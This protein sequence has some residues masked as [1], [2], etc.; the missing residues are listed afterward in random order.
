MNHPLTKWVYDQTDK[1]MK[2]NKPCRCYAMTITDSVMDKGTYDFKLGMY[3]FYVL[4]LKCEGLKKRNELMYFVCSV[5]EKQV[6]DSNKSE[7]FISQCLFHGMPV[8][9]L[10]I[11]LSK[12]DSDDIDDAR[13]ACCLSS[14]SR[15]KSI[16]SD[17]EI[18]MEAAY[19]RMMVKTK[20]F[21]ENKISEKKERIIEAE[22][23]LLSAK[24]E[25][26]RI[27]Y[28]RILPAI[29]GQL[30]TRER[31]YKETIDDIE[32]K[33]DLIPSIEELAIGV[34]FLD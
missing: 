4:H 23:R 15:V 29:R 19:H 14:D 5:G 26:E 12:Y 28:Q 22:Q 32:K 31:Q 11:R 1:F 27:N 21:Y 25:Q 10:S 33:K 16:I 13:K 18:D 3:V 8:T 17:F 30:E 20:S 9:D 7:F 34:V 24:S 6:F 2:S